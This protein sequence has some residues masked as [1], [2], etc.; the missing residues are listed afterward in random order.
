[1]EEMSTYQEDRICLVLSAC[2]QSAHESH[3][4]HVMGSL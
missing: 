4:H 1:M 3:Y 2:I